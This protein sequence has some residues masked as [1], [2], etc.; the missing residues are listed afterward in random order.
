M[1]RVYRRVVLRVWFGLGVAFS[2]AHVGSREWRGGAL[3]HSAGTSRWAVKG[4]KVATLEASLGSGH[5]VVRP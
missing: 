2:V 1:R 5:A 4:H 3:E